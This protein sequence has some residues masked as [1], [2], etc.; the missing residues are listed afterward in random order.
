VDQAHHAVAM[1]RQRY[2]AGA[3]DVN[4]A[5]GLS[6][7]LGENADEVEDGMRSRDRTGDTCVIK[8][9]GLDNLRCF[10]RFSRH[11]NTAG[12]AHGHA[13]R[14]ATLKKQRH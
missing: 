9:I 11:L 3:F 4:G 1:C 14:R 6:S 13:Y 2:S 7:R 12:M 10:G 8:Y 5:I